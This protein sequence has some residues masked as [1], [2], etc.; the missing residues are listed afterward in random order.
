MPGVRKA[1]MSDL[2]RRDRVAE[3]APLLREYVGKTCIKGSNPFVSAKSL[4]RQRAYRRAA[5]SC[6]LSFVGPVPALGDPWVA[7][8]PT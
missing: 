3:G 7:S 2:R 8:A 4:D 1:T 5:P 6:A